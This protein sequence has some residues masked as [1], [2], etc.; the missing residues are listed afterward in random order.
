MYLLGKKDYLGGGGEE[1]ST[2]AIKI[3]RSRKCCASLLLYLFLFNKNLFSKRY[4]PVRCHCP[5][6]YVNFCLVN[7][8]L[9]RK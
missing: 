6:I 1:N 2:T 7:F 5:K 8:S 3:R 9:T 4:F